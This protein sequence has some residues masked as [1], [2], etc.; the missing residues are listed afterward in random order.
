M[1][2]DFGYGGTDMRSRAGSRRLHK[3]N[4]RV[5]KT[6]R[7]WERSYPDMWILL[8]VTEQAIMN[9]CA[10][11]RSRLPVIRRNFKRNGKHTGKKVS[12]QC[13]P[14]V[15]RSSLVR[16][17]W[18]VPR[19]WA[20]F[21]PNSLPVLSLRISDVIIRALV[22]TGA[23]QSLVDPRLVKQLSLQENGRGWLSVSAQNRSRSHSYRLKARQS[24]VV[25]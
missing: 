18:P 15:L 19:S 20:S 9:R 13:R 4:G 22:D 6:I 21:P 7:E 2:L 14:T 10:E 24:V 8:E 23:S 12:S 5:E 1:F 25:F 17:W 16:R 3:K 11:K